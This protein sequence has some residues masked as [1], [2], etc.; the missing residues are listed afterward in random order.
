MNTI[1]LST[2]V[3]NVRTHVNPHGGLK[4]PPP[5]VSGGI[6]GGSDPR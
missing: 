6:G 3:S 5:F 2:Q 1:D 4:R